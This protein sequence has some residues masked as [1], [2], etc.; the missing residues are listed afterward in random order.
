MDIV[1]SPYGQQ[2]LDTITRLHP[3]P[4]LLV[5]PTGV[6][7]SMLA[8]AAARRLGQ[9]YTAISAYPGMDVGLLVGMW[10]PMPVNGGITVTWQDGALTTAV[11]QGHVC[12]FEE[13]SRAPQDALA[14]LFGLLDH[15]FRSWSVPEA[16][17]TCEVHPQFWFLGTTNPAAA[18]Y[19]VA[20]IDH[21]LE[22]RFSAILTI[23]QPL[24]DERTLLSGLLT[25]HPQRDDIVESLLRF[26]VDA[27]R[28][29]ETRINT[30]ALVFFA[31]HL[32]RGLSLQQA[33][34]LLIARYPAYQQ[35]LH[36]L[37]SVH[38]AHIVGAQQ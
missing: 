8:R 22:A 2:V 37:F 29:D 24:A 33:M 30:R 18:G 36:Q 38:F 3:H 11:R 6:G 26:A 4:V 34:H 5:G 21:A 9:E 19:A 23:T 27:R 25:Q 31:E 13:L 10:R 35:G 16:G 20:R 17:M 1:F 28:N 32:V 12:L 14:R 7:K 15:G